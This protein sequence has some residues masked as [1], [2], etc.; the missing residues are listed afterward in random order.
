MGPV[1]F[2]QVIFKPF[3]HISALAYHADGQ[4]HKNLETREMYISLDSDGNLIHPSKVP[5]CGSGR[6]IFL[7]SY[8]YQQI[9]CDYDCHTVHKE[10]L[11]PADT[12]LLHEMCSMKE[13]CNNLS[14]TKK[15][16]EFNSVKLKF[17]CLSK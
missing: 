6:K 17:Q 12:M 14:F 16:G 11:L 15:P 9:Q 13:T 4:I 5:D 1:R 2:Y 3:F 8:S 7:I 10:P